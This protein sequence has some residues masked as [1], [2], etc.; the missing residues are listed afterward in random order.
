MSWFRFGTLGCTLAVVVALV[1]GTSAEG[2]VRIQI[3]PGQVRPV[4][5]IQGPLVPE[6]ALEK[7][8]LTA[9]QKEKIEKLQKEFTDKTTAAETKIKEAREKAIQDM[10]REALGKVREMS[11]DLQKVRAEYVEKVKGVLT[12]EQVKVYEEVFQPVRRP[13][14]Q[15]IPGQRNA[16]VDLASKAV[17]DRLNLT[18][19][20]KEKLEKLQK[21][22][23]ARTLEVL[24]KEQ[25]EQFEQLKK[26]PRPLIRPQ[27]RPVPNPNP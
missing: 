22:Y 11:Q 15:V 23:E 14:V 12:P 9:E 21:E 7:L 20:Q 5:A 4:Q 18:A 17:Q 13:G 16:P 6:R 27:I 19:E 3:Q 26:Q 2:Q 1:N 25:K 8:N 10:N 24:T